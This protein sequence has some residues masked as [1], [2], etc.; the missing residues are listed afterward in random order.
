MIADRLDNKQFTAKDIKKIL[1]IDRNK[2]FYW[3]KTYRMLKPE[4]EEASGTGKTSK[5]SLKNLFEL[6][7]INEL[8][9]SGF[10]M[11]TTKEIKKSLD[12]HKIEKN[13]NVFEKHIEAYNKKDDSWIF[14]VAIYPTKDGYEV[15]L[16]GYEIG[17]DPYDGSIVPVDSKYHAEEMKSKLKR[18]V[19]T[20]I[21][22]RISD[23]FDDLIKKIKNY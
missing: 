2:L 20:K 16:C 5:Y 6:S 17:G 1:G 15:N 18:S 8:L 14:I 9:K 11:K 22:F 7:I 21:E 12:N 23:L 4:I 19:Y 3:I 10:D 13:L